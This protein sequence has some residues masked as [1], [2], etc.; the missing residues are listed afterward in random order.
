M[1]SVSKSKVTAAGR[2]FSRRA[3]VFSQGHCF[4]A[5]PL[6]RSYFSISCAYSLC[7][8][9]RVLLKE[10]KDVIHQQIPS[11]LDGFW[12]TLGLKLL[13]SGRCLED[14]ESE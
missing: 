6:V 4:L 11:G 7:K 8:S 10:N 14:I 12:K 9:A 5:G 1:K 2:T 13:L 3:I